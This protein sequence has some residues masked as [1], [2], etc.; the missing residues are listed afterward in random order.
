MIFD[1]K[2]LKKLLGKDLPYIGENNTTM[3]PETWVIMSPRLKK[4]GLN[5]HQI[6]YIARCLSGGEKAMKHWKSR[7]TLWRWEKQFKKLGIIK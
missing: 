4:S 3:I 7:T 6:L 2:G 1:K 5:F